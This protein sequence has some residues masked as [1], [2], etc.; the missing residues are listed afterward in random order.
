MND[1]GIFIA[2]GIGVLSF[3]APCTLPVL[4]GYFSYLAGVDQERN[5]RKKQIKTF[6]TSLAFVL[7]FSLI[8]VILGATA[9][10]IGQFLLKNRNLWQKIGGLIIIFFGLQTMGLIRGFQF[11]IPDRR[12]NPD[13]V[14]GWKGKAFLAGAGFGIGW[15]P[16][17]GPILGSI[18]VLASQTQTLFRG[19]GLLIAYALGLSIPMLFS[20]FLLTKLK[21]L[22]SQYI[23]S[24][25]GG[26]LIVMGLLLFFNQYERLTFG[27]AKIYQILKI[28]IF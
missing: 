12:Y 6:F 24:I 14:S 8:L 7:G 15:T 23:P 9:S 22:K 28:P 21:F 18:L 4:P 19:V 2:F 1:P 5:R 20:G 13:P 16:C 11:T 10:V 25:S 17:I 27:I 3:L 26:I